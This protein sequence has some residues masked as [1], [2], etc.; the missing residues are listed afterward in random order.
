MTDLRVENYTLPAA[1]L[2]P[3]NPLP[4]FRARQEHRTYKVAPLVSEEDRKYFGWHTGFRILP[5][6]MQDGYRRERKD[7]TI[8]RSAETFYRLDDGRRP[9]VATLDGAGRGGGRPASENGS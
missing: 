2:G 5:Y 4:H 7:T 6:R 9:W 8:Q 3:E 1:E